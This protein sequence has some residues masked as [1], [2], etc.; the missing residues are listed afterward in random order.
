MAPSLDA[1]LI[2]LA[3]SQGRNINEGTP[4]STVAMYVAE[5]STCNDFN[6]TSDLAQFESFGEKVA[7]DAW[8]TVRAVTSEASGLVRNQSCQASRMTSLR[9]DRSSGI[10]P[11]P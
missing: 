5:R 9:F 6:S 7:R 1:G 3:S 10:T 8:A 4:Y 11:R 2:L